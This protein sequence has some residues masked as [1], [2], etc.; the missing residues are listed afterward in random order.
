VPESNQLDL[1]PIWAR[2]EPAARQ[3]RFSRDRIA[4]AALG[5]ADAEGFEAVS[6]RRIAAVLGAG[7]MS[8]YRYIATR[9]DLLALIDD[10]L[11]GEAL[12]PDPLPADWRE[13]LA[14]VARQTRAA[15]LRHP[16]AV[17]LLQGRSAPQAAAV[18]PN[19]LRHFEQS[20]AALAAAPLDN[21]A[22]LDLLA[23]VDDYVIGHLVR[24]GEVAELARAAAGDAAAALDRFVSS[25]LETGEFPQITAMASEGWAR[26]FA[27]PA[28]TAERFERGLRLLIDGVVADGDAGAS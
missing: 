26:Q 21:T 13:A 22:R 25:G 11:L 16:W 1:T 28:R 20:L 19:A 24:A 23:M 7:T 3:P 15:Y 10:A 9:A 4:A 18:G 5:I 27:D 8:L 14:L 6:M 12:V 2:P 17:Q